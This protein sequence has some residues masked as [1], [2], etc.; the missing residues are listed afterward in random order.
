MRVMTMGATN[1]MATLYDIV[2]DV[3]H[4]FI[5]AGELVFYADDWVLVSC[6]VRSHYELLQRFLTRCEEHDFILHPDKSRLRII[7]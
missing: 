7:R 1:A 5:A 2:S 4:D 6:D 3:F